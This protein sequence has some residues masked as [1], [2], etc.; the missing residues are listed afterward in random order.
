MVSR[1]LA[2]RPDTT[3]FVVQNEGAIQPLLSLLR[4]S[5]RVVPEDVSV[6]ALCPEALAEQCSPRLTAVTGPAPRT[7]PVPGLAPTRKSVK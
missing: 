3:G 2:D 4:A 7:Q 1:I 5:G 6:V